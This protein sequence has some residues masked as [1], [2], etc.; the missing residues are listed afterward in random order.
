[1]KTEIPEY[2]PISPISLRCPF[3]HARPNKVCETALGGRLEVV[4]IARI[5]AAAKIDEARKAGRKRLN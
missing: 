4:H 1:M 3:C 2:L 5:K